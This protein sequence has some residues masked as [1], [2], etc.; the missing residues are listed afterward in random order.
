MTDAALKIP[1]KDPA[2]A[3]RV[4]EA[5]IK[6]GESLIR[7]MKTTT[8]KIA[9]LRPYP[10]GVVTANHIIVFVPAMVATAKVL[11]KARASKA[12]G[13]PE[14]AHFCAGEMWAI[15]NIKMAAAQDFAGYLMQTG[16]EVP[17]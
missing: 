11:L 1:I 8:D 16:M 12:D 13:K 5:T 9:I 4:L 7:T 10:F 14:N 3:D 17:E 15:D 2:H 6:H